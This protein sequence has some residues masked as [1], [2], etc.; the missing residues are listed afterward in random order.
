MR[1]V[2]ACLLTFAVCACGV[3]AAAA[4]AAKR[5]AT[6]C[7]KLA[8]RY[9]DR[10]PDRKLV[11]VVRGND[12]TGRISA[13]VLPSGK[14]RTLASWDDGLSRDGANILTTIGTWVIV[15][16]THGDQYGGV[17]RAVTRVNVRSGRR[18]LLSSY[19]CLLDYTQRTCPDGTSFG[20]L[21]I[22]ASGAGAY[23]VT[24]F[25]TSTTTLRSFSAAGAFA[26]LATGA[27]DRLRIE[28]PQILWS[29][30]GVE[31][32]APLP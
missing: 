1:A 17:S 5:P 28:G 31:H 10:S 14:V 25:A 22:A 23:E 15:E 12:E 20:E 30:A 26:T 27:V 32:A 16:D 21:V 4:T 7:Q 2:I 13:C 9:R 18:L 24:D 19:G 3:P 6:P 29:Q 8:K 11:L